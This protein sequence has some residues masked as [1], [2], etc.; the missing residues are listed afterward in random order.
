MS[1]FYDE[2]TSRNWAFISR[3]E[4]EAIRSTSV[5]C[6]GCGLG[7]QI[8]V[9]ALRTGFRDFLLADHDVVEVSNFNRQ[10]FDM[11]HL[12]LNKAMA[13]ESVLRATSDG[14]QIEVCDHLIT[15]ENA[16]EIVSRADIV[17]NTVDFDVTTF[18]LEATAREA[19]KPVLFPLNMGWGGFCIVLDG[20]SPTLRDMVGTPAPATK[21]DFIRRLLDSL[22][23]FALP[24]YLAERLE[25]LPELVDLGDRPAPQL[26]VAAVRTA[27]LVVEAM[28]RL[29]TGRD[30]RRA[31]RAL[32]MDMAVG[33]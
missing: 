11:S 26:G 32:S 12:G 7:S 27:S 3:K 22:E 19:H 8:A 24:T 25:E 15:P 20:D 14:L 2:L 5:L 18:A 16:P 21:A 13:L 23:G 17:V 10:A 4:Q 1:D 33:P 29:A 6:A 28:A 31:P 30:V 9:L